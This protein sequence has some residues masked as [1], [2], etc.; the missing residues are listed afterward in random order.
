MKN[1]FKLLTAVISLATVVAACNKVDNLYKLEPLPIFQEGVSPVL[2]S[3]VAS[4][5][6]VAADTAKTVVTFSWTNPK[7]A[8][9]SSTTKYVLEF[10]TTGGKFGNPASKTVN[11]ALSNTLTGRELNTI[12]LGYGYAVGVSKIIDIRLLSSYANNNERYV[13]NTVK[14]TV[15]PFAD[16]STLTST[17]NTVTASLATQAQNALTFSWS[18]SF[19]GYTGAV[20]YT[21]Q[22]DSAG[23]G[24]VAPKEVAA[25]TSFSKP[26]TQGEINT[27]ALSLGVV[28]GTKG[29]IA[30]RIKAVTALGSI[31]YSNIFL[32]TVNSY[33][34]IVRMYLAGSFQSSTGYGPDDWTPATGPEL[35]RDT[36]DGA[37]ND[38]YY[39]YIYLP[40]NTQFKVT[41]GRAWTTNFGSNN[42]GANGNN[43]S[44]VLVNGGGFNLQ[45]GP[46]GFY[47]I[48]VNRTTLKYDIREGRMGF[49][50]AGTG[51]GWTPG[52]VFP[53]YAM[54]NAA[55]NLFVGLTELSAGNQWKMIDTD[56]WDNGSKSVSEPKNYGTTEGSGSSL[57][58][59][60][61]AFNGV[62]TT[63]RY[64]AIWDGRNPDN[65]KYEISPAT[66]MR[67]VGDGINQ[68]GVG[69]WS[70][71]TSPG[72][73][74]QGNGVW[75]ISITL[76]A[77][78][79]IK[80]LAGNDWGAFDY[81]DNG[82][83]ADGVTH[84]IRWEGGSNFK[85]PAAAGTYTITLD[86][87]KQ[88]V[89]IN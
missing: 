73:A 28:G 31:V 35:I 82:L 72:M 17:A 39:I 59:N 37:L 87:N 66:E 60:R 56:G 84:K 68:A 25:G 70:P 78:K 57:I 61:D 42:E 22:Y 36:R 24:F 43:A 85:T 62:V 33:F 5:K 10:D 58:I 4:I 55:T 18:A 64:R 44:D 89:T 29:K 15:T 74:Y 81:E 11:G 49:V 27:Q 65:V 88:T 67:V 1:I 46:A 41:Q 14:L 23:M 54:G 19:T 83:A 16:S 30:Y 76:K 13:S 21:L 3:S 2:T 38:L 48:T 51:A 32:V 7:Y 9:D 86:E 80:F 79:D 69:D 12:L 34:P 77:G 63:G 47:R 26:F 20:T 52:N 8:N 53:A 71:A 40:E 45:V 6:P 50:G 75:T